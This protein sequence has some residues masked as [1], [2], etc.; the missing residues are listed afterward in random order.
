MC[1]F[2]APGCAGSVGRGD[3]P[4]PGLRAVVFLLVTFMATAKAFALPE[5]VHEPTMQEEALFSAILARLE[6]N[7]PAMPIPV[8]AAV[9]S[10]SAPVNKRIECPAGSMLSSVDIRVTTKH[11]RWNPKVAIERS[12]GTYRWNLDFIIDGRDATVSA[13][14]WLMI[15]PRPAAPREADELHGPVTNEALLYHEL[16]HAQLVMADMDTRAWQERI[17]SG[18][19]GPQASRDHHGTIDPAVAEYIYGTTAS[20]SGALAPSQ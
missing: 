8:D 13:D 15:D 9:A 16:L 11:V 17:C 5:P 20:I 19:A 1:W 3:G 7:R 10:F 18:M 12:L 4:G 2:P 6:L 14:N